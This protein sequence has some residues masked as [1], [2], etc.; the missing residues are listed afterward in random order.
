M[1]QQ[2]RF[3]S[4]GCVPRR[5]ADD[6]TLPLVQGPAWSRRG[7]LGAALATGGLAAC[8][9]GSS[10]DEHR[11]PSG[12]PRP[13]LDAAL[14]RLP[15]RVRTLM[16]TSGVPGVSVC[17]VVDGRRVYS[18]GFGVRALGSP[19]RVDADTVFQLASVSK[20]VGATVVA[21]QVGRGQVRWD[22]RM[23]TLL[24]DFALRDPAVTEALTVGDLYAHRSGLP[25]HAGDLLEDLGHDQ[26]ALFR[27]LRYLPLAPFRQHY[28]YTN[29][30]L[31]AAA[32]GV[33]RRAGQ[34]WAELSR[35]ALYAPLGMSRTTSAYAQFLTWENRSV[36]HVLDANGRWEVSALQRDPDVQS[37]AGGVSASVNDMA[38]WLQLILARGRFEGRQLVAADAL[39]PALSPQMRTNPDDP[40]NFYGF[41]FLVGPS[42]AGHR[43]LSHSGAFSLGAATAFFMVPALDVGIVVLTNGLPVGLPEAVGREF[44]DLVENGR[45]TRDWWSLY[46][47]AM[48]SLNAPVGSLADQ[49]PPQPAVPPQPLAAYVGTY[50][51]DYHGPLTVTLDAGALVMTLGPRPQ[52]L[53]LR[54]WDAETFV[55]VPAGE[56]APPGSL[57][58]A[59]FDAAGVTLE[60]FNEDGVGR[61]VRRA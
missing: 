24:S 20:A 35:E 7:F 4:S 30:G 16:Q 1:T 59:D 26:A 31:T 39:D 21:R 34:T 5:R 49:T 32:E 15:D 25:D 11:S 45:V 61:F 53:P 50:D 40:D 19:G 60:F 42:G 12:Q 56:S 13:G 36:G 17:V 10:E 43:M 23:Q 58:R 51:N 33:A 57:S 46:S 9:G 55:F 28:A 22:T 18:E 48:V 29:V 54:H 6:V 52:R 2:N 38:R 47:A 3:R 41:G 37:A 44:I 14:A 27:R 8:G